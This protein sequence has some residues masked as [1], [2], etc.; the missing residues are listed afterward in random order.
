MSA[1]PADPDAWVGEVRRLCLALADDYRRPQEKD[2]LVT[3]EQGCLNPNEPAAIPGA[4]RKI[5]WRASCSHARMESRT[6]LGAMDGLLAN[7]KKQIN[8]RIAKKRAELDEL[9]KANRGQLKVVN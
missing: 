6:I 4:V 5:G 9:E 1:K 7:L 8:D 2:S 3:L